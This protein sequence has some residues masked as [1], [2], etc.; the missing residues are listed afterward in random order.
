[1][2]VQ[3]FNAE[4]HGEMIKSWWMSRGVDFDISILPSTG[5]IVDEIAAGWIYLDVESKVGWLAW[6]I[7]DKHAPFIKR[8]KAVEEVTR[9]LEELAKEANVKFIM[10]STEN[11]SLGKLYS[12]AGF[13][14]A[15]EGKTDY[16][17][18]VS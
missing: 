6:T 8:G 3:V 9:L 10:A 15:E 2:G 16:I 17:K 1:M 14:V 5:F 11:K 4:D 13:I 7:A 12:K 18:R